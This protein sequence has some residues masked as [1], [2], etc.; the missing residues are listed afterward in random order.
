M[1]NIEHLIKFKNKNRSETI[2]LPIK[3]G[4]V[5][6]LTRKRA[7]VQYVKDQGGLCYYCKNS[8]NE[9]PSKDVLS[10]WINTSLFPEN[11][12]EHP[13]HLH[14]SHETGFTIG[15]VHAQCNAVLWQHHGE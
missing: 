10:K 15:A 1:A 6:W 3:Y 4:E 7:C 9:K 14:H 11:F 13:V 12:F 5:D 2:E 8:L